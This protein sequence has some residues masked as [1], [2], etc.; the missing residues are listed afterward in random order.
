MSNDVINW[1]F[2]TQNASDYIITFDMTANKSMFDLILRKALDKLKDKNKAAVVGVVD[3]FDIEER[4]YNL[5]HTILKNQIR[6]VKEDV[7]KDGI[8]VINS[9][10]EY[11]RFT[12]KKE[13]TGWDIKIR[14]VGQYGR[15]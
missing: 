11:G 4:Y 3:A 1:D 9:K 8:I 10:V 13:G 12:K 2:E 5:L 6:T 15:K 14:V 7:G